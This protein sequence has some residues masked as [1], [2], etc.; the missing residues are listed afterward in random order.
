MIA[1]IAHKLERRERLT[2]EDGGGCSS[3]P[4]CW[5]SRRLPTRTRAAPWR[6]HVLQLQHPH[7]STNVCVASCLFCSFAR[8]RPGEPGSYTMSLEDAWQ[9]LRVRHDSRS[10]KCTSSTVPPGSAVRVY[11]ER[12]RGSSASAGD[13]SE[14]F[15]R[16]RDCVLCRSLQNDRRTGVRELRTPVW[17]RCRAAARK[18]SP[19]AYA[20]RSVTTKRTP[21]GGC[22]F[23]GPRTASA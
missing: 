3:T 1:D 2:L 18:C 23:T 19:S 10:P 8:L 13:S 5:R 9:K 14:M 11:R 4:I 21:T 16:C 17:R 12:L 7:R 15:H 20:R 22:R 6:S